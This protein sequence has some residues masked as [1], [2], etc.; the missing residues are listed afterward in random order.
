V[1]GRTKPQVLNIASVHSLLLFLA[2]VVLWVRSYSIADSV[3]D[4]RDFPADQLTAT[5]DFKPQAIQRYTAFL[6]LR[7]KLV[8]VRIWRPVGGYRAADFMWNWTP[9][10]SALFPSGPSTLGPFGFSFEREKQQGTSSLRLVIPF[11][12]IVVLTSL[13]PICWLLKWRRDRSH[14]GAGRCTSCGYNLTGNTSGICPECGTPV[15]R[16]P[17]A[18]A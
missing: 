15:P 5:E 11:W 13:A 6:T 8:F 16:K 14:F 2:A 12:A 7:G 18:T 9:R 1:E 17:E 3:A 10:P 4:L